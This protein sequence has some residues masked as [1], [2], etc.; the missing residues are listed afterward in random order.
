MI[1]QLPQNTIFYLLEKSMKR[2]RKLAQ[3]KVDE[4]DYNIS[5]NQLILL[6]NLQER[7]K[8]SQV[9]LAELVFK[10]FASVA[11][12]V[13]LLV[14]KGYLKR[15]ES[16]VDR[17]KKDLIL[18]STCEAMLS[19]LRPVVEEYRVLALGDFSEE[20]IKKIQSFLTQLIDNCETHL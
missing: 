15:I 4:T 9:E 20:D 17:R 5:I 10:D 18:T 19:V 14:K 1:F 11:R 12:M 3:K 7:P 16:S 13:D 6:L 8:L 2:Y